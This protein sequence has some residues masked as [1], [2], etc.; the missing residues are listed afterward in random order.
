TSP[1][2]TG[3][4]PVKDVSRDWWLRVAIEG[5]AGQS[6]NPFQLIICD[7]NSTRASTLMILDEAEDKFKDR[8]VRVKE[9]QEGTAYALDACLKAADDKTQFF[10]KFD[11][12][13]YFF[14][15]REKARIRMFM[16]LPPQVTILYEN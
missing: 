10:T 8:I 12:D 14:R 5:A 11:A 2:L 15:D 16:S 4:M 3:L 13:D 1:L 9:Q 7:N 6:Y